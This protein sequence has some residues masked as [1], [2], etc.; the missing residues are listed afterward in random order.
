MNTKKVTFALSIVLMLLLVVQIAALFMPF[1]SLSAPQ[2]THDMNPGPQSYSLYDFAFN[3]TKAITQQ[4]QAADRDWNINANVTS[5]AVTLGMIG[6]VFFFCLFSRK[7]VV[8]QI[9]ALGYV[10]IAFYSFW[11]NP[12]LAECDF[13]SVIK[14]ARVMIIITSIVVVIRLVVWIVARFVQKAYSPMNL[15]R[16]GG[17]LERS[18]NASAKTVPFG[19]TMRNTFIIFLLISLVFAFFVSNRY[20]LINRNATLEYKQAYINELEAEIKG[21]KKEVKNLNAQIE[22]LQTPTEETEATEATEETTDETA[23]LPEET[24]IEQ[25]VTAS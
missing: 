13:P 12:F 7:S 4:F 25:P 3:N 14:F 10:A 19:Y 8:G 15:E 22:E 24:T 5:F 1:V 9:F 6:I 21:L 20:H 17:E 2:T 11:S 18:A 16:A 23:Q